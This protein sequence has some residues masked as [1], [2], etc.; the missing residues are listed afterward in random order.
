MEPSRKVVNCHAAMAAFLKKAVRTIRRF[1]YLVISVALIRISS[2]AASPQLTIKVRDYATMPM[3]GLVGGRGNNASLAR[4]DILREE[5]GGNKRRL[6]VNDING[7]LYILGRKCKS[8]I[9]YLNFNGSNGQPGLFHKLS[10]KRGNS[11]GFI[12]FIFDPD[13]AHN[14]KFYTIHIEDPTLPGS[15]IP[16]NT[17]FPGLNIQGYALTAPIHTPGP[18]RLEAVLIEWTDTNIR[19][20]TFEGTARELMRVQLNTESHPMGGLIFNPTAKPGSPDWRV[21]YISCGDSRA[22]E[23]MDSALRQNPQRLDTLLGKILRII[24]DLDEHKDSSTVSE[25]G[26]YRIPNDNPFVSISDARKEIWAY[27]LRNPERMSWYFDPADPS[28]NTLFATVVG[29]H[30]WEVVDIIHKGA[31]YGYSLREGNQQLDSDNRTSKLP[32]IDKIPIRVN[33]TTTVGMVTPTYPVLEYGHMKSGG[34]AISNG[35]VYRGKIATL[36]GKYVF[37]DITTGHIWYASYDEMLAADDGNPNTM[38][39][40]H[41]VQIEWEK[42][43]GGTE[44]YSAMAPITEAAY[45]VRGGKA[46]GLPGFAPI[47]RGRADIHFSMDAKGELYILSKSDG[48]IRA[49]VGATVL[50]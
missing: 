1:S 15:A 7:P 4:V 45:H 14:G 40:L 50:R 10:I 13:Y 2:Y 43:G 48:M 41:E 29:L 27:G 12:N 24:P 44:R 39:G 3:T 36:R 42:P 22:G 25:N 26:R 20:S 49:V 17:N 11:D 8:F 6:F 37:G 18:A 35:Y 47:S 46:P 16:D 33:A 5:P 30:T 9:T 34:D 38:A 31:N 23:S 21:L 32:D 28:K 19:N